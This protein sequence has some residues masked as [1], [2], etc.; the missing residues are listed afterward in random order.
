M[1]IFFNQEYIIFIGGEYLIPSMDHT[2]TMLRV[3]LIKNNY[4]GDSQNLLIGADNL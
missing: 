2:K 3:T 1:F 4:L